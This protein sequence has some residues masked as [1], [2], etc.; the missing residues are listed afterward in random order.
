[1][2][3]AA[4][5]CEYNPFHKGHELHIK[6]TKEELGMPIVCIMSGN[7]VQRGDVAIMNKHSRA[8]AA[9]HCGADLVIEL[10]TVFACAGSQRFAYGAISMLN[11]LGFIDHL[12]FG[13][14]CGDIDKLNDAVRLAETAESEEYLKKFINQGMSFA[15]ARSAAAESIDPHTAKILTEPN[16]ILAIEYIRA[17]RKIK[18]DMKPFTVMRC[19]AGHDSHSEESGI[20]DAGYIRKL[21]AAGEYERAV[22]FMPKYA[23]DIF[24]RELGK[25][26]APVLIDCIENA[27]MSQLRR[28]SV[29]DYA[30]LPDVSEG[31]ENRLYRAA[32]ESVTLDG[33]CTAAKTK[34]YAFARLRRIYLSAFLGIKE[35]Y[36]ENFKP[37]I[38]VLA[39]NDVGRCLISQINEK[40][41]VITKPAAINNPNFDETVKNEFENES[42]MTD[43][44]SLAYP[45]LMK[46][47]SGWEYTTSPVY[48]SSAFRER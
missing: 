36:V 22:S 25:G 13:S 7:Y 35:K 21:I 10:P 4:I 34:R 46:R 9:I 45:A 16:N 15:S 37:Y 26:C 42:L 8:E 20:A 44:Y 3:A 30:L 18:S 2:K 23:A 6:Q 1:M 24:I 17:I 12:S 32:K 27:I 40:I 43:M 31:L 19:G 28:L 29:D 41:T 48:V 38:R 5:I 39:L 11:A 14:E 47:I 33:A